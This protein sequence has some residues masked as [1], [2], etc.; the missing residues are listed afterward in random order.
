MINTVEKI[1]DKLKN[2][3]DI[4]SHVWNRIYSSIAPV[5]VLLPVIIVSSIYS[6]IDLKNLRNEIFQISVWWK[7]QLDNEN[8][9]NIIVKN[10]HW[11]KDTSFKSCYVQQIDESTDP[12][13]Q[14]VGKHITLK[15]KILENNL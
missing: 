9:K 1:Y 14:T 8:I 11:L 12:E 3:Q 13:T 7:S 2:N 4:V 5:W 6:R 15:L 10:F